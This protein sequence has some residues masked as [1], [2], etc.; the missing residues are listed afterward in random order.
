M[1]AEPW[2]GNVVPTLPDG[3]LNFNSNIAS[4]FQTRFWKNT[5]KLFYLEAQLSDSNSAAV[6]PCAQPNGSKVQFLHS[7]LL[8]YS[9]K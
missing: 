7:L 1:K 9:I 8:A 6:C 3:S 4:H 2:I 5:V